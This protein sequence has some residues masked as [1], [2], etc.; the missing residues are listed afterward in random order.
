MT[1]SRL[2]RQ[3]RAMVASDHDRGATASEG[4]TTDAGS[5]SAEGAQNHE[6]MLEPNWSSVAAVAVEVWRLGQR[7][8]RLPQPDAPV[9]QPL[10]NSVERLTYALGELGVTFEDPLG[11]DFDPR[12]SLEVAHAD[13][14]TGAIHTDDQLTVT[15]TISPEIRHAGRVIRHGRV[16]VGRQPT[17]TEVPA[18]EAEDGGGVHP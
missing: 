15:E 5:P 12:S 7:V 6:P 14:P 2:S 11:T 16:V 13:L 10:R 8:Q 17:P 1:M 9:Y 18:T 3:F 4:G